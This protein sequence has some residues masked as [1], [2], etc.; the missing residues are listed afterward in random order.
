MSLSNSSTASASSTTTLT[1]FFNEKANIKKCVKLST[2]GNN[3]IKDLFWDKDMLFKDKDKKKWSI[4]FRHMKKYFQLVIRNN[5]IIKT[6]YKFGRYNLDG[7]LYVINSLGLQSLQGKLRNYISGEY[8]RDIDIKNCH[9][10]ILLFLCDKYNIE[11]TF[12]KKYVNDRSNVLSEDNLTKLD[13]LIAINTDD[14]KTKKDKRLYNNFIHEL[15][16]IK[17]KLNDKIDDEGYICSHTNDL[18]PISS[19]IDK[20]LCKYENDIIQKA[21]DYFK[22]ENVGVPMFDGLLVNKEC[23][24]NLIELNE[25]FKDY[26]YIEFIEKS[27]SS[28][29]VIE[30]SELI[31]NSYDYDDVKEEFEKN[32]FQIS[33]P[34]SYWKNVRGLDNHMRYS[35]INDKG[36]KDIASEY[37]IINNKNKM[38]SIY[39][40]WISDKNKR[41]YDNIVFEPYGKIDNCPKFSFNTFDGFAVNKLDVEGGIDISNFIEFL[42]SFC[43]EESNESKPKSE[44]LIK[45]LAH[46]FQYPNDRTEKIIVFKGSQGAGKDT[47]YQILRKLMGVAY[48]DMVDDLETAF[49]S[50]NEVLDNKIAL[51]VNELEGCDGYKFQ[52]K[53]KA[54]STSPTTKINNK[55]EKRI[56]KNNYMR[57]FVFSNNESPVNIETSDRRYV[58]IKTGFKLLSRTNNKSKKEYAEKFFSKFYD[59]MENHQWIK[60]LYDYFMNM[61]LSRFNPRKERVITEEYNL[62]KEK[63]TNSIYVYLKYIMET[64]DDNYKSNDTYIHKGEWSYITFKDFKDAYYSYCETQLDIHTKYKDTYIKQKLSGMNKCY[65]L[66]SRMKYTKNNIQI[67]ECLMGFDFNKVNEF[68]RDYIDLDQSIDETDLGEI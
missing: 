7:R 62:L 59:D 53:L 24:I 5:G 9:P 64:N 35:Q 41:R 46:M 47:L 50:F 18:N 15:K 55:N 36:L 67:R 21:I 2:L 16:E 25:L 65:K 45:Y 63:N 27:T 23:N 32:H 57:L 4:Y 3:E 29:I 34:F 17:T 54:V 6:E 68:M 56:E 26:K 12:L 42:S 1:V 31:Q 49:G 10:S 43:D 28:D 19:K 52:S 30:D 40:S 13:Y 39:E 14:N 66:P 22:V 44:W 37:K 20:I 48:C 38:T 8:Y 60:S 58:V 33:N 51:F 11:S 61:D